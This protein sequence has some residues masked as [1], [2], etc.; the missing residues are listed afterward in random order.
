MPASSFFEAGK[1]WS[2]F[3]RT[4]FTATINALTSLLIARSPVLQRLEFQGNK[5]RPEPDAASGTGRFSLAFAY[6]NEIP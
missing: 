2:L 1:A 3:P 6:H 4:P 5:L